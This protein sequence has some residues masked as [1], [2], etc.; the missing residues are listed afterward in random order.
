MS[1]T[2]REDH[3]IARRERHLVVS[4]RASDCVAFC[5]ELETHPTSGARSEHRSHLLL[6]GRCEAPGSREL[7]GEKQRTR[8]PNGAQRLR[9]CVHLRPSPAKTSGLA[10]KSQPTRLATLCREL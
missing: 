10:I 9:Q 8:Y 7:P 6:R 1:V 4:R 3:E 5:S 2:V